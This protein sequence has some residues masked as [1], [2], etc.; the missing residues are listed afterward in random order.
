VFSTGG[1]EK[2][3]E[4]EKEVERKR[5]ERKF[6]SSKRKNEYYLFIIKSETIYLVCKICHCQSAHCPQRQKGNRSQK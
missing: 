1:R 2:E 3:R 5:R 6:Y 4:R